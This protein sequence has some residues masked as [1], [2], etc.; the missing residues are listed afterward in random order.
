MDDYYNILGVSKSS[1]SEEIKD[2]F[3]KKAKE[4]HPDRGGDESEFKK[5]NEAYDILKDD[6]RRTLYDRQN[7]TQT[8]KR[9]FHSQTSGNFDDIFVDL[10]DVFGNFGQ[11]GGIDPNIRRRQQRN[12]DL[13]ITITIGLEELFDNVNKTVSVRHVNGERKLISI[14]LPR[15]VNNVDTLRY[16]GL[17]DASITNR[18]PGDL[19]VNIIIDEHPIFI[20]DKENLY[21]DLTI[22]LIDAITGSNPEIKTLDGKQLKLKIGPGTQYGT[23]FKIPNFGMYSKNGS[24]GN[25]LI[26][27]LVKIPENLTEEQLNIIRQLGN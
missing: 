2:A 12:R 11:F 24:R 15:T 7:Q 14:V 21:M 1:S 22:S 9:N 5:I 26:R 13:N 23:V 20:K 3:R 8:R 6:E 16:R 10:N 4:L 17:G 25:L 27:I 18:P 19:F